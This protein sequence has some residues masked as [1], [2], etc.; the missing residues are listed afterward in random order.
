MDD[1]GIV[2]LDRPAARPE[3]RRAP[4]LDPAL[5]RVRVNLDGSTP[6]I[7]RRL[8]IRSDV[9]L[10]VV[11]QV[12]QAAFGWEDRHLHRFAI[13]GGPFDHDSQLF[14]CP[15]DA[16]DPDC[17]DAG[18]AESEVRLDETLGEPGDVLYYVYDYGDFWQVT[19]RLEAVLPATEDSPTAVVVDGE[20][21]APPEDCGGITDGDALSEIIDAGNFDAE[22]ISAE[23]RSPFFILREAGIDRRLVDLVHRLRYTSV[24]DD[25]QAR[26]RIIATAPCSLDDAELDRYLA[27]HRWFLNRAADGALPLTSSGWLKPAVLAEAAK[28]IPEMGDWPFGHAREKNCPPL[29]H[30]RET[31]QSLRLVRRYKG[32]LT[33]TKAGILAWRN[34]SQIWDRLAIRLVPG[35]DDAYE[36]QSTLLF[37][38]YAG[39]TSDVDDLP[40]AAMATA[41]NE[42]GWRHADG[43]P[44]EDFSLRYHPAHSILV[45]VTDAPVTAQRRWKISPGAA[46]LARAAL[47]V[48]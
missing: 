17:D 10:D 16:D 13:G 22:T 32:E 21:A 40:F 20:R 48:S 5:Y 19:L 30:F 14:L 43:R 12:L 39:T 41:L 4:R 34:P 18:L 11:H 7:W 45:N 3:L 2:D 1:G 42:L 6:A 46:A 9:P 25:L 26:A 37:L 28:V 24:G 35:T 31:L 8:D 38:A 47:R 44:V 36:L 15:F 27:A 33:L 23:L 29:R